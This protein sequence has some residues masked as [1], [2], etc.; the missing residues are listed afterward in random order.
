MKLHLS[1]IPESGWEGELSLPLEDFSR[2]GEAHGSQQGLCEARLIIRNRQGNLDIRGHLRVTVQ[3]ACQRCLDPVP[4]AVDEDVLVSMVPMADYEK[5]EADL[6]LGDGELEVS[7]YQGE[8]I[9]LR[10]LLEDELLLALPDT[11]TDEDEDG[12]C[13]HCG[14]NVD[15]LFAEDPLKNETHPFAAMRNML[16]DS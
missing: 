13:T 6:H 7:F 16:K 9:D 1:E 15:A 5:Q 11:I 2:L 12:N 4:L 8:E 14:R 3:A 10:H